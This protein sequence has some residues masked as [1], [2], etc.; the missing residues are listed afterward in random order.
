[1]RVK[2]RLE[3]VTV[4]KEKFKIKNIFK[5]SIKKILVISMITTNIFFY[6][7]IVTFAADDNDDKKVPATVPAAA[8]EIISKFVSVK[9]SGGS[10]GFTGGSVNYAEEGDGYHQLI[11]VANKKYKDYKQAEGSYAGDPYWG[12]FISDS[13]CGLVSCAIVLSGYGVDVTPGDVCEKMKAEVANYSN[14]ENL[15]KLLNL[16]GL[17]NERKTYIDYS[18]ILNDIRNN[19]QEGRPVI[20]GIDGTSDGTYSYSGHWLVILGEDNGHIITAN[21]GRPTTPTDDT[22][23]NFIQT[24]MSP[25]CGYILITQDYNGGTTSSSSKTTSSL[26]LKSISRATNRQQSSDS[27]SDVN[28]TGYTGIHKSGITGREYKEYKQ[29]ASIWSKEP[30]ANGKTIGEWG[31][32]LTSDATLCTGYGYDVTPVDINSKYSG[33]YNIG[34]E[35]TSLI[36]RSNG[37]WESVRNY[38]TKQLLEFLE[39]GYVFIVHT[40]GPN[41]FCNSEHYIPVIDVDGNNIYSS[42]PWIGNPT[43]WLDADYFFS[44]MNEILM[45]SKD[46]GSIGNYG[47]AS[48]SSISAGMSSVNMSGN[49]VP[50]ERDGYKINIDLDKEIDGMLET[51]KEKNFKLEKYLD[52]SVQKE[53]LKNM[54]KAAIVTQYPDLRS[55]DEIAKDPKGEKTPVNETQGCIKV[56]R[57]SDGE[58]KAF[59]SNSLSNPVDD[60]DE[61]KGMYLSYMPYKEFSKLISNGD[62]S[63]FNHFSLDSRNNLVVA[64]WET[65]DVS[66]T[67]EKIGGAEDPNPDS[68]P[69]ARA[70]EYSKLVEKKVN[71][72]NQ[73][74]NYTVPFSFMWSLLVYGNDEDFVNDFAKLVIDTEIVIASYDA[75]NVKVTTYTNTYIKKNSTTSTAK[76]GNYTAGYGYQSE[77][78]GSKTEAYTYQVTEIHTLKTNTPSLKVKYANTW[79][80]IYNN[81]YRIKKEESENETGTTLPDEEISSEYKDITINGDVNL[82]EED[83]EKKD[84]IEQMI[85]DNPELQEEIDTKIEELSKQTSEYNNGRF[86]YRYTIL[87]EVIK[88]KSKALSDEPTDFYK[89]L[90]EEDVQNYVINMII[91]GN[92]N[93]YIEYVFENDKVI[94]RCA[95]KI[96][97]SGYMDVQKEAAYR[98]EGIVEKATKKDEG[99]TASLRDK[100][101]KN[102]QDTEMNKTYSAEVTSLRTETVEK[103]TVQQEKIKTDTTTST[104]EEVTS[105]GNVSMKIDKNGDENS[106]VKLLYHSKKAKGNLRIIDSWFFESMEKTAAIADMLDLTKYLLEIVYK[107][108]SDLTN[109]EIQGLYNLFDPAKMS[110]VSKRQTAAGTVVGG[111]SYSSITI[112]DS[113]LQILYK[114]VQAE[115][116][117][118]THEQKIHKTDVILNRV[119][120]SAYPDT[121]EEVVFESGQFEPT[122]SGTYDAAVPSEDTISAVNDAIQ[123]GDQTNGAVGFCDKLLYHTDYYGYCLSKTSWFVKGGWFMLFEYDEAAGSSVYYTTPEYQ[124]ELNQYAANTSSNVSG[125]AQAIINAAKSR[126]GCPYSWGGNGP[127]QFDCSGLVCWCYEQAGINIWSHRVSLGS[128]SP[129]DVSVSDAQPGDV[130]YRTDHVALCVSNANGVLTYIHAPQTGDVVKEVQT[131]NYNSFLKACRWIQ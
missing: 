23:E 102:G 120:L 130:L 6:M 67:I 36:G 19:L 42:D 98:V 80:A 125:K 3:K 21:P 26:P 77:A 52:K 15:S 32:G 100:L 127:N 4:K 97:E 123:M 13:G 68:A 49:I 110:S 58:T 89:L 45:F 35:M 22:L 112:S 82:S 65:L 11:E 66:V 48:S 126:L 74:T 46:G 122:W 39:Q 16:Y 121:I 57:Y 29:N 104:V 47:G 69:A 95:K 62:K 94:E 109:E 40:V 86:K 2:D 18:G 76:I 41:D 33:G 108:K 28:S 92:S 5:N 113:D 24:Q 87:S 91:S 73:I 60:K 44:N 63:A 37:G 43:G 8:N 10:S 55:A 75:T 119:L 103:H 71:Y 118:G 51:L 34:A 50:N 93:D 27:A 107:G 99:E 56:K 84:K 1:M 64:G 83:L 72:I 53:Y 124:Q 117:A 61:E 14:S 9:S 25:G 96:S 90:L 115:G 116:G 54:I 111:A 38:S 128:D 106:F 79:T 12:G 114:I 31:C 101:T 20:V 105:N 81:N 88:E 30:Y 59:A 78:Q 131:T 70:E 85:K 17:S 7:P 129:Q